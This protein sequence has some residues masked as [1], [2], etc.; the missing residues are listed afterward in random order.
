MSDLHSQWA[1]ATWQQL[2][3]SRRKRDRKRHVGLLLLL[4]SVLSAVALGIRH[5]EWIASWPVFT[6]HA[7]EVSG[8]HTVSFAEVLQI[9][10]LQ[11]GDPWWR[12]K[13]AQI[14]ERV[15]QQPRLRNLTERYA[16]FHRLRVEV[17]ERESTLSV[18]GSIGG[19]LTR[20]GLFLPSERIRDDTDL[21]ILRVTPGTLPVPGSRAD[22]PVAAVARLVGDIRERHPDLWLDLSEF[23]FTDVDARAYLRSRRGVIV[24]R[25]GVHE[26]LWDL[27]PAVLGDLERHDRS[28]IV[29]DLRFRDRIVVHL[30]ETLVADTLRAR[31]S[32]VRT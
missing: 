29:L 24:F 13:S 21:P 26:E 3:Q 31:S 15:R 5:R 28:D 18:L 6:I 19:E 11:V 1:E 17:E 9:L 30:P 14:Q 22:R 8:N 20:D 32:T 2:L 12:V 23:E 4:V 25:P 7:I 10:D 27:V 16:W